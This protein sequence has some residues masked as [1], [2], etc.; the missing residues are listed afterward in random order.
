[1]VSP[2]PKSPLQH[3]LRYISPGTLAA[4]Q[5]KYRAFGAIGRSWCG[6]SLPGKSMGLEREEAA[7]SQLLG[8]HLWQTESLCAPRKDW[9]SG[10]S[11]RLIHLPIYGSMGRFVSTSNLLQACDYNMLMI[12]D[13]V[14]FWLA[15]PHDRLPQCQQTLSLLMSS[16]M[17]QHSSCA[18]ETID[19]W[20]K[21]RRVV[22]CI[23][24]PQAVLLW[25]AW[26]TVDLNFSTQQISL[27]SVFY[28][29]CK[30]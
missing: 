27:W 2:P 13:E 8:P 30:E 21:P 11:A 19:L 5:L 10:P 1:M 28:V 7:N 29:S 26:G 3:C 14:S 6:S 22:D 12:V 15:E 17:L 20:V 25:S 9:A 24:Q 4:T 23:S 18:S 16:L